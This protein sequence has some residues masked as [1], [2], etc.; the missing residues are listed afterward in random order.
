[1]P[2]LS[3]TGSLV[4]L[5]V[6]RLDLAQTQ[7]HEGVLGDELSHLGGDALAPQVG[8]TDEDADRRDP[9]SP[10]DVVEADVADAPTIDLDG[11]AEAVRI[12]G[13]R[14]DPRLLRLQAHR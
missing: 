6:T 7:L 11:P 13:S 1:D 2:C 12:G 14:L 4:R 5:Q 8:L 9:A 3:T 10:V